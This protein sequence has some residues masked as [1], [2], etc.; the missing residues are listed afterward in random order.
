VNK[1]LLRMRPPTPPP[2]PTSVRMGG[3]GGCGCGGAD[4]VGQQAGAAHGYGAEHSRPLLGL[5][6]SAASGPGQAQP[7]QAGGSAG[8]QTGATDWDVLAGAKAQQL[9]GGGGYASDG[10][11][12]RGYASGGGGGAGAAR[13]TDCT[14]RGT[15]GG[16]CSG[17]LAAT[18]LDRVAT[19][20]RI[21]AESRDRAAGVGTMAARIERQGGGYVPLLD[22]EV[23]GRLA[24]LQMDMA[25]GLDMLGNERLDRIGSVLARTKH[26]HRG[27][28]VRE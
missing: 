12:G 3:G 17:G 1:L 11:G 25:S 6:S 7:Y 23:R 14:L 8:Q 18:S 4:S 16:G 20:R 2:L 19:A 24:R 27:A 9:G 5:V 28:V 22:G 21:E 10:G 13:Q 26:P 15:A